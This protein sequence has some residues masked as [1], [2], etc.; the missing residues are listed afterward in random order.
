MENY[1]PVCA[2]NILQLPT[3]IT[4]LGFVA[5]FWRRIIVTY[6]RLRARDF[7]HDDNGPSV[8]AFK[9]VL[10]FEL[11]IRLLSPVA[12]L[13]V[14]NHFRFRFVQRYRMYVCAT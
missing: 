7:C 4:T 9:H 13:D 3:S 14:C 10:R 12:R 6:I 2:Y 11:N 5:R 8:H 1:I